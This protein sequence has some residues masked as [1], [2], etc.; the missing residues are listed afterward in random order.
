MTCHCAKSD[1]SSPC[2]GTCVYNGTQV[3]TPVFPLEVIPK[4]GQRVIAYVNDDESLVPFSARYFKKSDIM[5]EGFYFDGIYGV[6]RVG[7]HSD[8]VAWSPIPD[9]HA[10]RTPDVVP[11]RFRFEETEVP[12]SPGVRHPKAEV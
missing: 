1:G 8:V 4:Q 6:N 2:D 10:D 7:F 3:R 9:F 11:G 5:R 12:D